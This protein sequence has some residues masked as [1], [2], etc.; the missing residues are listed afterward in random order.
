[1]TETYANLI[2]KTRRRNDQEMQTELTM[3]F[4]RLV[5]KQQGGPHCLDRHVIQ[6]SR[7]SAPFTHSKGNQSWFAHFLHFKNNTANI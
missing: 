4:H 3:L 1:M 7:S 2:S 6:L 5:S